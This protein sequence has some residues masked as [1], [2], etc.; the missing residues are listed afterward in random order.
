MTEFILAID[1]ETTGLYEEGAALI[2]IGA[3]LYKDEEQIASLHTNID[4]DYKKTVSLKACAINRSTPSTVRNGYHSSVDFLQFADFLTMEV[5]PKTLDKI[6]V[7][8]HN[9]HFDLTFI[10]DEFKRSKILGWADV[11]NYRVIDTATIGSFLKSVGLLDVHN[12][13]LSTLAK[14]L[15]V[16]YDP[17]QH[18]SALYDAQLS[19]Q[20]YFKMK[21]LIGSK[22]NGQNQ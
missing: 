9:V 21:K 15:E 1:T 18:H 8:G 19:A 17:E 2:E 16:P 22:L 12:T 14:H 4:A 13:G 6:T 10:K 11:V 20:V 3:V 5:M 7:L